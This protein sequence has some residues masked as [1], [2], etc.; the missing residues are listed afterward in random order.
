MRLV[1]CL[2][3]S[4]ALAGCSEA[5]EDPPLR[6]DTGAVTDAAVAADSSPDTTTKVDAGAVGAVVINEVRAAD[7]DYVELMNTGTTTAD[8]AGF[9]LRGESGDAG[10]PNELVF[11]AGTKLS[12][13]A[14]VLIYANESKLDAG[15]ADCKGAP[16]AACFSV[17]W[18]I[19]A[20]RGEKL[21]FV[22]PAGLT[23]SEV[24]VSKSIP[25]GKTWGRIPNGTGAFV[26]TAPT[27]GAENKP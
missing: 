10:T 4:I 19:S 16:A 15:A 1:Q 23:V 8:L 13:G 2:C 24:D 18:G 11:P 17:Q 5:N 9:G 7:G 22:D 20:T 21:R 14:Y 3:F 25:T 27:P 6:S 12:A 26:D